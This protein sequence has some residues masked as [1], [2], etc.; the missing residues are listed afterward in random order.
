[1]SEAISTRRGISRWLTRGR[2][3]A[4][5]RILAA[6]LPGYAKGCS[7]ALRDRPFLKNG[8]STRLIKRAPSG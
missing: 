2:R 4:G 8:A 6:W 3:R 5:E 7:I 1:L